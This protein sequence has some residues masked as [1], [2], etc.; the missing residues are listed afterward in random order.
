MNLRHFLKFTERNMEKYLS[1]I[2]KLK[3]FGYRKKNSYFCNP[4]FGTKLLIYLQDG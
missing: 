3:K 2:K 4:N 1:D